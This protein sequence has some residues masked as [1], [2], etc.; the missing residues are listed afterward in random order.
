MDAPRARPAP[1]V[2]AMSVD[3]EDYFHVSAFEHVVDRAE[4]PTRESR[5][6]RNTERL[7][8]A[9][10][11]GLWED[12]GDN[13]DKLEALLL[14]AEGSIEDSLLHGMSGTSAG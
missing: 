7:L 2:N 4:W 13:K 9:I 1:V 11:R 5:V 8:E 3:V 14:E 12:P 6:C 10:S